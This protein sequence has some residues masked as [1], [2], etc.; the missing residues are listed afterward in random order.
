MALIYQCDKCGS[1]HKA[2][3]VV[4]NLHKQHGYEQL[5]VPIGGVVDVC[6][7]CYK[8]VVAARLQAERESRKTV[9]DR[10]SEIL[11]FA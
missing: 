3:G 9:R 10:M 1:E 5:A 8:E 7:N 6:E 11:G 4:H 2:S